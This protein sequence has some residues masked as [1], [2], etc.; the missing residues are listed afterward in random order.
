MV[1]VLMGACGS[2]SSFSG[3]LLAVRV[4]QGQPLVDLRADVN[5]N[6]VVELDVA[7]EDAAED[8]W[9]DQHGAIFLANIDDDLGACPKTSNL[10]DDA[11]AQC[12]DARDEVVNGPDDLE[13][14]A[15]LRL[16]PWP[17]APSGTTVRLEI[18][19]P[20]RD[21]VRV[22]RKAGDTWEIVPAGALFLADLRLGA[23]LR[24]EGKDIVR[25]AS[26]WDGFVDVTLVVEVPQ[27]AAWVP[28]TYR[29]TVRLR[30][31]PVLN[32]HHVAPVVKAFAADL[33]GDPD[34]ADF[35]ADVRAAVT[36]AG[37][38]V[39]L[40]TP[41][42]E[43]Q[44]IQDYLETGYASM[45]GP[46]G[47]QKVMTVVYRSANVEGGGPFPLRPAGRIV[48]TRLRGKDV[49][50]IQQ[51]DANTS[52]DVQSLNSFGN[53]ETIPPYT[54]AGKSWPLGRSI[55]GSIPT[56][57][58]D[59]SF[60]G[61]VDSQRYQGPG[62]DVDTSWLLV[63]HVDETVSFI[64]ANSPRGWV[65]LVNDA[66]MAKSM[67]EAEVARGNGAVRMFVGQ[68]WVDDYGDEYPA[69]ATI[70]QVLANTQVMAAS[71]EA[72]VEVDKHIA[73]LKAETGLTDAEIVRVPFLHDL[74]YDFS[75]AYQPGT[76]NLFVLSDSVV[77][78][79]DPHG[80]IIDGKDLFK[81]QLEAA[82]APYQ[83][84]VKWVE[85]WNL[86]HRLGGEV[87]C[88]TNA[89]RQV[90]SQKWWEVKP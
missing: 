73:I 21:K 60:V 45:P 44:W 31:A 32:F 4:E 58:P 87:H 11:L 90:P 22:F 89:I 71:A 48:F 84:T 2:A 14:L 61:M 43:D 82:L 64:K 57:A 78:V 83:V 19:N 37:P 9:D 62:V 35:L 6:G 24:L 33:T 17:G 20:G 46:N 13:D 18:A 50:G 56:F 23:E 16:A 59:Q 25:N 54:H 52:G 28:G 55:R 66:R 30:V 49:G 65:L 42:V 39:T 68:Q 10:S 8:T 74:Y 72:A 53:W 29:D 26:Q 38:T 40:D 85:N 27:Q 36:A 15:P 80:P 5:R 41:S 88:G 12:N 34:S 47:T 86:Y 76:V 67:L 7:S 70:S 81:T 1:V 77:A 69:Q 79:P 3:D 51:Y 63:G 75:I